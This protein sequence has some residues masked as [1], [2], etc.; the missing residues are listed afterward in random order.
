[1]TGK[2]IWQ[3][4]S[5]G[6]FQG[7]SPSIG[8]RGTVFIGD[9][10]GILHAL[11]GSSGVERWSFAAQG[12]ILQSAALGEG[13]VIFGATG[14]YVYSID[15]TFGTLRWK[16]AA[17]GEVAST[18]A[19]GLDGTVYVGV[20]PTSNG[21]GLLLALDGA[22]GRRRWAFATPAE[23]RSSPAIGTD[24]TLYFGCSDGR[25]YA[26]HNGAL[27]W[28]FQTSDKVVGSPALSWSGAV[29]FSSVNGWTYSLDASTGVQNWQFPASGHSGARPHSQPTALC[30]SGV[31]TASS[32]LLMALQE[33]KARGD[34]P[35]GSGEE[36]EG[37]LGLPTATRCASGWTLTGRL[38][39]RFLVLVSMLI[40][41]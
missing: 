9:S 30:S 18:P 4:S 34:G 19:I 16:A 1:V 21:T 40:Y 28:A 36:S 24:G 6:G 14:G 10:S 7:P 33:S 12:A 32:M 17:G 13:S 23:V 41:Y 3:F 2:G 38:V 25:L 20:G 35:A 29:V 26:V 15:S 39:T 31:R 8:R 27:R 37:R 22:T 11:E 5:A